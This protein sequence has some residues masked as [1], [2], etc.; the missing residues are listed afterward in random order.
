MDQKIAAIMIGIP[1]SGKTSFCQERLGEYARIAP[2]E[3]QTAYQIQ[4]LMKSCL[5]GDTPFVVDGMN[6]TKEERQRYIA[7]A[8]AMGFRIVGYY[9]LADPEECIMRNNERNAD[10]GWFK[11]TVGKIAY[12]M[13]RK[14]RGKEAA[15]RKSMTIVTD[16]MIEDI[17]GMM[18]TPSK[19]EGFDELYMVITE[20]GQFVVEPCQSGIGN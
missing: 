8:K 6:I 16:E 19:E 10:R 17:Y 5:R 14:D 1:C 20:K 4:T 3:A 12:R 13:E 7:L 2:E 18:E 15:K 9:M 11:N